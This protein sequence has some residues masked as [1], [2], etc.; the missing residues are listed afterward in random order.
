MNR[1]MLIRPVILGLVVLGVLW[2]GWSTLISRSF[3][4]VKLDS[5]VSNVQVTGRVSKSITAS[6]WLNLPTGD[7]VMTYYQGSEVASV[8]SYHVGALSFGTVTSQVK[9]PTQKPLVFLNHAANLVTP[10]D[11]GYIYLDKATHAVSYADASGVTNISSKFRLTTDPNASLSDSTDTLYDTVINIEPI[12]SGGV[13][14][15]TTRAAFIVQ[16]PSAVT[17]LK[18][19]VYSR[20]NY[21]SSAYDGQTNSLF[22]LSTHSKTVYRY[23]VSKPGSL[24]AT[25]YTGTLEL[26][27][28]AA[29]GG[30][31]AAYYDAVPSLEPDVL[32]QYGLKYQVIPLLLDGSNGKLIQSFKDE[33][34]ATS[35]TIS[36]SGQYIAIKRKLAVALSVYDLSSHHVASVPTFDTSGID[37][38]DST[39]Y[40]AR[41]NAIWVYQPDGSF[42]KESAAPAPV[43]R[44]LVTSAATILTTNADVTAQLVPLATSKIPVVPTSSTAASAPFIYYA[45]PSEND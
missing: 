11:K 14:V 30:K 26:N 18:T 34:G 39:L 22:V 23:D 8:Q 3:V 35:V 2:L 6:S 37:W 9:E 33:T 21:T 36:D 1:E 31:V 25:F 5:S 17:T 27:R 44:L 20:P 24:P 45:P 40:V 4:S 13:V 28:L 7:Y 10:L 16:G 38:Q 41:D 12:K 29:G 19:D 42:T 32:A 43:T 15:T